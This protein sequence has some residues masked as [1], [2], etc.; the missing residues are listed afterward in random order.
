MTL[1]NPLGTYDTKNVGTEKTVSVSGLALVGANKDNY[2]LTSTAASAAIGTITVATLTASL[3]GT[4]QKTY[5]GNTAAALTS[6]NYQLDGVVSEDNV[7]LNNP[8]SGLYDTKNAGTEKTV[9][10]S[11]LALQG[12]DKNNYVLASTN[13]S[14]AVGE[15]D[16]ATLTASLTGTVQKTYDGNTAATL[17]SGN[18]QLD[19]VVSED[20]VSLNSPAS[21]L[22]DN[23]NAGTEKT[24]F[25]SGLALQGADKNNYILASTNISGAVGEIDAA[26]LTASLTGTVQKTYDG[27]T[28]AALT[29]DNYQLDGVVSEDN[30]TLNN[31]AAGLYDTKYAEPK[32]P[33]L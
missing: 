1:N 22:Y 28:S 10:V 11:G 20:N 17:T 7:S 3:T 12:A 30:V 27:T 29:S 8:A 14:G 23:K 24:V 25:V 4:V 19:G 32:R 6:D 2:A 9:F 18:Y 21:G 15:I 31:P 13:I 26:T 5:D 16:A 33:S